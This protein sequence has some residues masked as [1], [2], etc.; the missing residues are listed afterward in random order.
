MN[1]SAY[2]LFLDGITKFLQRITKILK[3]PLSY[4]VNDTCKYNVQLLHESINIILFSILSLGIHFTRVTIKPLATFKKY[5]RRLTYESTN[6]CH[7][8]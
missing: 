2:I 6:L 5:D 3:F 4:V 8:D 1:L 7:C